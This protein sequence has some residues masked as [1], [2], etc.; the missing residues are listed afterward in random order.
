MGFDITG[1]RLR[2]IERARGA[3]SALAP[4]DWTDAR[5]DAWLDWA[6]ALPGDY[7]GVDLPG[8]LS[9]DAPFEPALG[10]IEFGAVVQAHLDA[11]RQAQAADAGAQTICSKLQA[12]ISAVARCEGEA[13]ACA[14]PLRNPALITACRARATASAP[15]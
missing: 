9:P 11:A 3:A 4:G 13:S 7:P 6:E 2:E 10:D 5:V 15:A 1:L 14:D 12:V 8:A